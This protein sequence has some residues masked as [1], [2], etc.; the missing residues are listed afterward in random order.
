MQE[1][2][3]RLAALDPDAGAAVQVIAYFDTLLDEHAGLESFVRGAAVLTGCS[4]RLA[5][6]ERRVHVR[7]EPDGRRLDS[8]AP[9]DPVWPST[10]LHHP[11]GEARV[12]IERAAGPR[13]LD[14]IVLERLAAGARVVLDRT[15]GRLFPDDDPASVEVLLDAEA[16]GDIRLRAARR[17]G[18]DPAAARVRA[19]AVLT[20]GAAPLPGAARIG[21][22]QALVEHLGRPRPAPPGRVGI[23][24]AVPVEELPGS[25]AAA[26]L[27]LRFTAA[28]TAVDPGPR[29]V[30]A[31]RLGGLAVLAEGVD[32]GAPVVPD[33]HRLDRASD[34]AP[35]MLVTLDAVATHASLRAAATAL[36]VHH[37]TLRERMRQAEARLGWN[38]V[39]P[40]GRLRLQLALALRRLHRTDF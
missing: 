27:A 39:E 9:P 32:R 16:S 40:A 35:W 19:L 14:E 17:L 6:P 22:A 13:P 8:A 21:G 26:H 37:S 25:W 38:A 20:D 23:G 15:R 5:D 29:T 31:D 12:W 2:A 1:L 4:A 36:H 7:V 28:G 3:A 11:G 24:P 10:A 33:V 34:A 30:E 18:L